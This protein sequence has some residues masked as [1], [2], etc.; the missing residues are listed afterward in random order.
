MLC[1]NISLLSQHKSLKRTPG[2]WWIFDQLGW[3]PFF[4]VSIRRKIS[5]IC[6]GPVFGMALML[7]ERPVQIHLSSL[8]HLSRQS[9]LWVMRLFINSKKTLTLSKIYYR[10]L[11]RI[12]VKPVKL[13]EL[14]WIFLYLDKID[15]FCHWKYVRCIE[16]IKNQG[17][18]L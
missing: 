18:W 14:H 2:I 9:M 7:W 10:T 13:E 5:Q 8:F 6:H 11:T 15:V 16:S 1:F 17:I 3:P 12:W 4:W